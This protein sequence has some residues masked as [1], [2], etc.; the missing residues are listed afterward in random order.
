MLLWL[1]YHHPKVY[2]NNFSRWLCY[3]HVPEFCEWLTRF[4]T[5]LIFGHTFLRS[6]FQNVRKQLIGRFRADKDK[7]P[8]EKQSLVLTHFPRFLS[9][10]EEELY[11]DKSPIWDPDFR[12]SPPP[13]V[14]QMSSGVS[15]SAA[16][17]TQPASKTGS[18]DSDSTLSNSKKRMLDEADQNLAG[19]MS[20]NKRQR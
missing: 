17:V 13:H 19:S 12:L 2:K 18:S 1:V 16:S 6:V 8:D 20:S 11:S 3:S 7:M 10:L 15:A 14:T 5:K 4:D 9:L